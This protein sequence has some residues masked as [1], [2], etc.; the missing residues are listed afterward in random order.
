MAGM[1]LYYMTFKTVI[2]LRANTYWIK[3]NIFL[4][5]RMFLRKNDKSCFHLSDS[6]VIWRDLTIK[7][8]CVVMFCNSGVLQGIQYLSFFGEFSEWT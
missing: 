4:V 6:T 1:D 3:S 7:A 8:N 5:L 2:H